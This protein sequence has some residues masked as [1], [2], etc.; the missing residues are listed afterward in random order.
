[1][2]LNI[3]ILEKLQQ[4]CDIL[5][6]ADHHSSYFCYILEKENGPIKKIFT[7]KFSLDF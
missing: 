3:S 2:H 5:F 7:K 1:M 6:H 4:G